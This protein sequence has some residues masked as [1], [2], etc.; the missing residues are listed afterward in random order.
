VTARAAGAELPLA[1]TGDAG[2]EH[3]ARMST[4]DKDTT[5]NDNEDT[6]KIVV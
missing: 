1:A 6:V 3:A 4:P 2:S 5:S